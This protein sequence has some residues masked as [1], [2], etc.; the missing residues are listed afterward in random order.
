MKGTLIMAGIFASLLAVQQAGA[1][2]IKPSILNAAG[3]GSTIAGNTYSYSVGEMAVIG[4]AIGSNITVTQGVL[5]PDDAAEGIAKVSAIQNLNVFPNPANS[6]IN[7][8]YASQTSSALS[9]KL[10]DI[11][12]KTIFSKSLQSASGNINEQINVSKLADAGYLLQ[13]T[14]NTDG[15]T[16]TASYKIQKTK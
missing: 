11:T 12:G 6:V 9:Y 14:L 3:G 1:Q 16:Q 15:R 5:Q 8:A 2:S 13:V 10:M 7:V 4:T